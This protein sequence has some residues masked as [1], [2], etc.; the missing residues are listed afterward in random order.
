MCKNKLDKLTILSFISSKIEKTRLSSIVSQPKKVVL[1]V[2][3]VCVAVFVFVIVG[4]NL[5]LKFS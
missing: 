2:V 5:T 1:G 4:P 3:V